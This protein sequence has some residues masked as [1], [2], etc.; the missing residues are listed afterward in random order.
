MTESLTKHELYTLA[1]QQGQ[2]RFFRETFDEFAKRVVK[3]KEKRD[4]KQEPW[5]KDAGK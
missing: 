3:L 4:A 1:M 2:K 5:R